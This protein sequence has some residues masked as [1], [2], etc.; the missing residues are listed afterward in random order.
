MAYPNFDS[1]C[2]VQGTFWIQKDLDSKILSSP[3]NWHVQETLLSQNCIVKKNVGV[4]KMS[5]GKML[6]E[7]MPA[8]KLL[9]LKY[10]PGNLPLKF[11]QNQGF[12][13]KR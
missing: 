10:R 8:G 6:T 4:H 5:L 11:G 3:K 9:P 7:Q 12:R 2:D 13:R 1:D